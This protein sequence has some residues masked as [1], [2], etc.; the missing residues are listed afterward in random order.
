M[1][2]ID[3]DKYL[4]NTTGGDLEHTNT[5]ET[6]PAGEY[7]AVDKDI[8][9][10]LNDSQLWGWFDAGSL[11]Y[12]EDDDGTADYTDKYEGWHRLFNYGIGTPM[13]D[14]T[15]RSASDYEALTLQQGLEEID[16]RQLLKDPTGFETNTDTTISFNDGTLTFTIAPTGASF[17]VW[18]RGHRFAKTS[19]ESVVITD[20]EG[21]WFFYYTTAGVLTASQTIWDFETHAFVAAIYWDATN[22]KH[23][24]LEDE[25]HGLQWSWSEHRYHHRTTFTQ[26]DDPYNDFL[27]GDFISG[28]D[29]SLDSHATF[30]LGNGAI[31]DEDLKHSIA[32]AASP[33]N[34]FE[35]ILS[36]IAKVPIYYVSGTD[37]IRR[38]D[39]TDY[40]VIWDGTNTIKYNKLDAGVFSLDNVPNGGYCNMFVFATNSIDEPIVAIAGRVGST[41]AALVLSETARDVAGEFP[42][43]EYVFLYRLIFRTDTSY[44]NEPK[45]VLYLF[46]DLRYLGETQDRY[47]WECGYG[48]LA[49]TDRYMERQGQ[50]MDLTPFP[51]PEDGF[52][53]TVSLQTTALNTG[54]M[55]FYLSTDLVNPLFT[56][57][58]SNESFNQ[59][60]QTQ[61]VDK[62]DLIVC[63]VVSGSF[64]KPQLTVINQTNIDTGV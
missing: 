38:I 6:W 24:W 14:R 9:Y 48:A 47:L 3:P 35:Q 58:F 29:G 60:E 16:F 59:F 23:I 39:A 51:I 49:S 13:L 45:A 31:H 57:S 10:R 8:L 43:Q 2:Q 32:D 11:Y 5:G 15:V 53:R 33:S 42:F 52:I 41:N 19:S 7:K 28:G 64:N 36:P 37:D 4:K 17:D 63:K 46:D 20:T 50:S 18:Q 56:I 21:V 26:L 30:G 55:G 62:G 1:S 27:L 12:A 44:T 61:A 34:P 54:V 40:A 25:R 22:N